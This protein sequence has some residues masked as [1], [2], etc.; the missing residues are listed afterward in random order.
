MVGMRARDRLPTAVEESLP[1]VPAA[2]IALD[3]GAPPRQ[4]LSAAVSALRCRAAAAVIGPLVLRAASSLNEDGT[5]R[6]ETGTQHLI[7]TL[8]AY[9]PA[10]MKP[11]LSK[12]ERH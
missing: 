1:A 9:N 12:P 3:H 2:P 4:V 5:A 7:A 6:L 8:H 10:A 11:P